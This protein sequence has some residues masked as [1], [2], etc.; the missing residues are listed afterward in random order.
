MGSGG[1]FNRAARRSGGAR[2]F[3]IPCAAVGAS[4]ADAIVNA[5]IGKVV[6]I[7]AERGI[8]IDWMA[9]LPEGREYAARDVVNAIGD[10]LTAAGIENNLTKEVAS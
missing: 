2:P 5:L 8:T 6:E 9:L 4:N 1:T 10:A 7:E 3:V